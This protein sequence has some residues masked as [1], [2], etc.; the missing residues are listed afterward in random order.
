MLKFI[1]SIMRRTL[2]QYD[3]LPIIIYCYKLAI[4]ENPISQLNSFLW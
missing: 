4:N 1:I 3:F 2:Q